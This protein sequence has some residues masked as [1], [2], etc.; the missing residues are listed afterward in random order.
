MELIKVQQSIEERID[1]V[2]KTRSVL[3]K[4]A[5][6]KA[7]TIAEYEKQMAITILKLKNGVIT[8]FEGENIQGL[9]ATV[10]EKVAK[11]I[12]YQERLNADLAEANYKSAVVALQALQ[13]ELN[14]FQSIY[15][16]SEYHIN[17]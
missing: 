10:L 11:G 8:K 9:P 16:H 6:E 15:K 5:K 1:L 12:C 3:R 14:G 4:L 7:D 13:A 17:D 2:S